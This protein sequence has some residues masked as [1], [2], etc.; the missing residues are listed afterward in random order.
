MP[1]QM[2]AQVS[3]SPLP[4][5]ISGEHG[6]SSQA[7]E[8]L[9]GSETSAGWKL[10][11]S[12]FWLDSSLM[13]KSKSNTSWY[14]GITEGSS[15][16][17]GMGGVVTKQSIKF[18]RDS[19]NLS[20]AFQLNLPSTQFTERSGM[21]GKPKDGTQLITRGLT[22]TLDNVLDVSEKCLT[23]QSHNASSKFDQLLSVGIIAKGIRPKS[24]R[25]GLAPHP[26]SLHPHCVA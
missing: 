24:Y 22:I 25:E 16:D 13:D 19:M 8:H 3:E 11:H 26:S 15:K 18:S 6:T 21:L 20:G 5:E 12:S 10:S 1:F 9:M 7:G 23:E 14:M 17:G 4:L 2:L